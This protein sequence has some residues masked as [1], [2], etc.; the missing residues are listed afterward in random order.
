M[1]LLTCIKDLWEFNRARTLMT[2][3]D[4]AKQP[5]PTAVLGWRPG[6]G[7]AHIAWQLM[8]VGITEE[9]FATERLFG[10]TAGFTDLIP[11]FKGGSTPDDNIPTADQ[12]RE[13]LNASRQHLL[14][15]LP[16]LTEA[17]LSRIP[18][19]GLLKDRG[20]TFAKALQVITWHEAH[21]Q[22][23][24]HITLNLWKNCG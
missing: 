19:S 8:H 1:S 15:G 6:P 5:D 4:I 3:D 2:L 12:I 14:E 23:Q 17:D 7:R 11:R 18:D 16:R 24:A 22:G 20:W 21:H 9:L 10:A 13:V